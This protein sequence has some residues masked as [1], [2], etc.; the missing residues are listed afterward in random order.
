M[1]FAILLPVTSRGKVESIIQDM[2]KLMNE[3]DNSSNE[4]LSLKVYYGINEDDQLLC[5]EAIHR[6]MVSTT[7]E[8]HYHLFPCINKADPVPICS[9]WRELAKIAYYLD[10]CDYYLLLGDDVQVHC[11]NVNVHWPIIVHQQFQEM[12]VP[13]FGVLSLKDSNSPGFCTFPV[14]S[15]LHMDIFAGEIIPKDFINQ[16]GDPYLWELYRRFN[17]AKLLQEIIVDNKVGGVQLLEDEAY[18]PPRYERW[19]VDWKGSLLQKNVDIL[20]KAIEDRKGLGH[21]KKVKVVDI[22]VPSY[23]VDR[24]YILP[25]INLLNTYNTCRCNLMIILVIDNP[26]VEI[27]WLRILENEHLRI[28]KNL[29][30]LGSSETRNIGLRESAA[31]WILFLDDDVTPHPN[32]VD[33][34]VQA[35]EKFGE[36]YAGFVGST[37]LP[38]DLTQVNEVSLKVS[39]ITYFWDIAEKSDE[40]AWG[41]TA[42]LMVSRVGDNREIYFNSEFLKTGGGEDIDFCLQLKAKSKYLKT[43]AEAVCDHKIW[44]AAMLHVFYWGFSD[45]LLLTKY[46]HLT[47]YN[48]PNLVEFVVLVLVVSLF[49][50]Y[51]WM[52]RTD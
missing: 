3:L 48:Y 18:V 42:N 39:G 44:D 24:S 1:K 51:F 46:P 21:L 38:L 2:R 12:S 27:E 22:V 11:A 36:F 37:R 49:L 10:A 13:G 7:L 34:Y 50:Q 20:L 33:A 26:G 32:I 30:N 6:L 9:Y 15:K 25:I 45:S 19:H 52:I 23:R 16:D 43:V 17:S 29:T 28:R 35:I 41:I 8:Y 14:V 40:T 5:E 4:L 47:Y 31:D